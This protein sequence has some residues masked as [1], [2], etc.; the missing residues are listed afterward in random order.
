M[1]EPDFSVLRE[2]MVAEQLKPRGI[3]D[4]K[5]LSAFMTVP[6]ELFVPDDKRHSAYGDYPIEIG[7]GQTIS[8]PY[9]VAYMTQLLEIKPG[10]RILE[11]GTG[12][13]YQAAIAAYLDAQVFTI[14][15]ISHLARDAAARLKMLGYKTV[16]MMV[17]DGTQ[18]VPEFAPYDKI[19]VTAGART[20]PSPLL[21]Q[22]KIGGTLIIPLGGS[23]CQKLTLIKKVT[24][25]NLKT[26]HVCDCIFV[27]LVG[28][29][30]Y[31]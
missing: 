29:N 5:V 4:K 13:G 11:V 8:Q 28:E 6:R 20:V 17:G 26:Q 1:K 30:G 19:I 25:D 14:E 18:G 7:F 10:E 31:A 27:P 21:L 22:L 2:R 23:G 12:S 24:V 15:R 9:I 3:V 16:K